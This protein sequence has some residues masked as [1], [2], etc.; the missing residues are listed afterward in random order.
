MRVCLRSTAVSVS[1]SVC[2]AAAAAAL[3]V[4]L[5]WQYLTI[6]LICNIY[7]SYVRKREINWVQQRRQRFARTEAYVKAKESVGNVIHSL[8]SQDGLVL[9]AHKPGDIPTTRPERFSALPTLSNAVTRFEPC[10]PNKGIKQ[11]VGCQSTCLA[12]DR[13]LGYD[14]LYV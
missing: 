13:V 11:L 14:S 7:R 3:V 8:D 1:V 6:I 10:D 4:L 9:P 12:V 2:A 5:L